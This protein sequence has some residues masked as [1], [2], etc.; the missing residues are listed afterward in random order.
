ML[1]SFSRTGFSFVLIQKKQKIKATALGDPSSRSIGIANADALRLKLMRNETKNL[2]VPIFYKHSLFLP[3]KEQ[4]IKAFAL[5][6]FVQL[7]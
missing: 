7:S 4:I 5:Y 3:T 2:D 6:F 1:S